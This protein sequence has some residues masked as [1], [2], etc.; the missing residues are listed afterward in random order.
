[1]CIRWRRRSRA[2]PARPARCRQRTRVS[3]S[4][5]RTPPPGA[6]GR[7][8]TAVSSTEVR[9]SCCGSR[10]AA[11]VPGEGRRCQRPPPCSAHEREHLLA[12]H[13]RLHATHPRPGRRTTG[14]GLDAPS[15]CRTRHT[16]VSRVRSGIAAR[17]TPTSPTRTPRDGLPRSPIG[18]H[19]FRPVRGAGGDAS[20]RPR[21][22]PLGDVLVDHP[23]P[24][25]NCP[26][27]VDWSLLALS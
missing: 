21:N 11:P 19:R 14:R 9:E 27:S 24:P 16:A 7:S 2:T 22:R 13:R 4:S 20:P 18:L 25:E 17:A 1:V 15:T 6:A 23:G 26:L 12:A 3:T 10:S 5:R 8:G